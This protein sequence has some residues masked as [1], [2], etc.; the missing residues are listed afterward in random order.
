MSK[1]KMAGYGTT[2][3]SGLKSRMGRAQASGH[4]GVIKQDE[5][6]HLEAEHGGVR[7]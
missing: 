3:C 5:T 7:K 1:T 2:G 4:G 6:E